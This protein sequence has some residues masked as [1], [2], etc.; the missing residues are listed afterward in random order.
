MTYGYNGK[1]L[2]INLTTGEFKVETPGPEFYQKYLGGSALN[3]YYMLKMLPVG[4]DPLGPENVLAMSVG[5]ITGAAVPGQS[6][7]VITAKSPLTGLIGDSQAGGFFPA[8]MKFSGFDA[9]I[10]TGK[11]PKPVYLW[12]NDGKYELR[13][14]A[15]LWGKV[16]GEAEDLIRAELGDEK[17]EIAQIGPAGE[18]KVLFASVMNMCNRANGRTGMGAVMGS[19]NLKAVAVRGKQGKKDYQVAHPEEFKNLSRAAIASLKGNH[20]EGLGKYG[21][22]ISIMAQNTSGQLPTRNSISGHFES[23]EDISGETMYDHFLL[24]HTEGKQDSLGRDTCYACPIRCK[25]VFGEKGGDLNIDPR[26]GGPEYETLGTLGS[27]CGVSDLLAVAK[28]NEICNKYGIDTISGG[29][30]VSWAMECF[31][32]G[33]IAEKD[34]GGIKLK[35]G[36]GDA[37]LKILEMIGKREGFGNIL[38]EGSF[39]AARIIGRGSEQYVLTGNKQ[40]FPAHM[41]RVKPGMGVLYAVNT[42]GADHVSCGHDPFY[43][44]QPSEKPESDE[45]IK[46]SLPPTLVD[47]DLLHPTKPRSLSAQKMQFI[48]VTQYYH[49][50]VDSI[51]ICLMVSSSFGGLV[52]PKEMPALINSVT[53]W[54]MTFEEL[55]AVGERRVNMM[56]LFNAQ[57]GHTPSLNEISPKIFTPLQ[58]GPSDGFKIEKAD[59]EEAKREYFRQ[60]E[61]DLETGYPTESRLMELGLEWAKR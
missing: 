1:I 5:V 25:R 57:E 52:T 30:T 19:K 49:S 29:I 47:F 3:V 16:T 23:A 8:E 51:P 14:A 9:F 48:R 34:T 28:A 45:E 31:D 7:V 11:S 35:F 36:N 15:H 43:E 59:F 58:G 53:G 41:P 33:I 55:L 46:A 44:R 38:A 50:V 18:N 26:Y 6:R 39:R 12:V 27:S 17:I 32:K 22:A 24:G 42:F 4:V 10:F 13:D 40:E 54:D 60:Q 61:W 37:M 20:L 21:T 2:F 56:Q